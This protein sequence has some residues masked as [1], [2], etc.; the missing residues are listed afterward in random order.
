MMIKNLVDS[1]DFSSVIHAH[2]DIHHV[3]QHDSHP[4]V[5]KGLPKN[6]VVE[7]QVYTDLNGF[8]PCWHLLTCKCLIICG[9][10]SNYNGKELKTHHPQNS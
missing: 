9:P 7:V 5:V 1:Y 2:E 10:T 4:V 8:R 3:I 6:Q